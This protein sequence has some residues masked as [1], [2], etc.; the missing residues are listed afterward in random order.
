[1]PKTKVFRHGDLLLV[2]IKSLPKGLNKPEKTKTILS[3]SHGHN[4]DYD[5]G[6][7]YFKKVDDY[8][9][10]YFVAKDTVIDHPEHGKAEIPN[11][12][13]ELRRPQEFTPEG[14]KLI[15]D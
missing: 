7:L 2:K 3:G 9:F 1:M 4:H 11:G 6:K 13:Y 5:N 8:V 15:I 10:G 12:T 14:L